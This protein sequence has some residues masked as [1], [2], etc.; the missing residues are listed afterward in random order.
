MG[1]AICMHPE[2]NVATVLSD[3]DAGQEVEVEGA[4]KPLRIEAGEDVPFGHKI[5]LASIAA[6]KKIKKYGETIGIATSAIKP[7]M[8]VHVHNIKSS[9]R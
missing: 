9:R 3:V 5:A 8:H 4:G 1:R 2:D 7:G 6:Q